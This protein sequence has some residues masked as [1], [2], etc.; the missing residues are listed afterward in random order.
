MKVELKPKIKCKQTQKQI[1]TFNK[2]SIEGR[3]KA[4]VKTKTEWYEKRWNH[5]NYSTYC[6]PKL[7]LHHFN[8]ACQNKN[9]L[10]LKHLL[11]MHI[12]CFMT[13]KLEK[14]QLSFLPFKKSIPKKLNVCCLV[15]IPKTSL[16][17][18]FSFNFK[19]IYILYTLIYKFLFYLLQ[20]QLNRLMPSV[21][22]RSGSKNVSDHKTII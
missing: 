19:F 16:V 18:N 15:Y 14:D 6:K 13:N 20:V 4:E 21:L 5:S 12:H 10:N 2:P 9:K 8:F 11:L 7:G 22:F 1:N 3:I 17:Q